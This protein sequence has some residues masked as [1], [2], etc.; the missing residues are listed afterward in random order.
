MGCGYEGLSGKGSAPR[1][2]CRLR[3]DDE[4]V[5]IGIITRRTDYTIHYSHE[6]VPQSGRS[7]GVKE[8]TE[9]RVAVEWSIYGTAV[10]LEACV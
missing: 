10:L 1:T 2:S 6:T 3:R 8:K 5:F 7:G 4:K 9:H